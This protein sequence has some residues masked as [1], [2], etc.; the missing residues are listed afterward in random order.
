MSASSTASRRRLSD[1]RPSIT[2]KRTICGSEYYITVGFYDDPRD[3]PRDTP[4]ELFIKCP[5]HGSV[6]AGLIDG[7][8]TSMSVAW[9]YGVPWEFNRNKFLGT[10]FGQPDIHEGVEQTSFLDG[11]AKAIDGII[12]ER[13][14]VTGEDAPSA[15]PLGSDRHY[16]SEVVDLGAWVMDGQGKPEHVEWLT[17]QRACPYNNTC[18]GVDVAKGETSADPLKVEEAREIAERLQRNGWIVEGLQNLPAKPASYLIDG[19]HRE[20]KEAQSRRINEQFI[21]RDADP[22]TK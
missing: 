18:F 3:G 7:L 17:P 11:L 21:G 19:I 8:C 15:W 20:S 2:V 10:R 9:Q 6:T 5:H 1:A 13:R 4:A 14:K 16:Q 22:G 12:L